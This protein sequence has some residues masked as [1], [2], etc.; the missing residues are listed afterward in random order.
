MPGDDQPTADRGPS[1]ADPAETA[2]TSDV[3]SAPAPDG[4]E[5]IGPYRLLS[6]IGEGGFGVVWEADQTE[7][8]RRRVAMKVIKPGM[9]SK[10]VVARFEAER[11]AL[12]VMDHPCIAKVLDGGTTPRD[13][14]SRPYFVMELVRGE[15]ITEFCDKHKLDL[16]AR[17]E[18]FVRVCEAVQHAHTKG[19]IHRDL[20]PSN[21]LVQYQDG[22]PAP[23]VIDFGVAK[24]LNQR[25][26][27]QTIFTDRGQMIGTPEYM[28]PEQAEMSGLD[29]DTRSDVYSL[30]VVLYE[31]LTGALPFDPT[32]LR[33]AGF[34]EI[35]RIIREVEPPKPSTR[36][37][38]KS[39]SPAPVD[40]GPV[41]KEAVTKTLRRDL[42]WV[43]MQCLD[44]SRER[45]YSSAASLGDD[46]VRFLQGDPV[47]AGP[48]GVT[49]RVAKFVH[50]NRVLVVVSGIALSF[51][52][53]AAGV[54]S[55]F[56]ISAAQAQEKSAYADSERRAA[57]DARDLARRAV[58]EAVA[59]M[60][61][62]SAE[63]NGAIGSMQTPANSRT[64][65]GEI[66]IDGLIGAA[67]R[68]HRTPLAHQ[69]SGRDLYDITVLAVEQALP[70]DLLAQA[71]IY[72]HVASR[73]TGDADLS[74]QFS[75]RAASLIKQ[76]VVSDPLLIASLYRNRMYE[77]LDELRS[78]L[79]WKLTLADEHVGPRSGASQY[80]LLSLARHHEREGRYSDAITVIREGLNRHQ[81]DDESSSRFRLDSERMLVRSLKDSGQL[82]AAV[83][84]LER[85]YAGRSSPWVRAR[86]LLERSELYRAGGKAQEAVTV[87][88]QAWEIISATDPPPE[89][90]TR[91]M[92]RLMRRQSN[93]IRRALTELERN[94]V[95][96]NEQEPNQGHN[97]SAQQWRDRLQ[98]FDKLLQTNQGS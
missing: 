85:Q 71:D 95:L 60:V 17:V 11:Q 46:L 62:A 91:D 25:L 98:A 6:I 42:D 74:E 89:R 5:R 90:Y 1:D 72:R 47:A 53:L 79:E 4:G 39:G 33:A 66:E 94:F 19:V 59:T 83:Q 52:T 37:G 8:V 26:T 92:H 14:G 44:K 29:I 13:Q 48:P 93:T 2:D 68:D 35:Q 18:L 36:L 65:P 80:I 38:P 87:A 21:I 12:A 28:S 27:E 30:G 70:G 84:E 61:E 32:T 10:A 40:R 15:P 82:D 16:D 34:A 45:R 75:A 51:A 97:Q 63:P 57:E 76:C 24:A 88:K 64:L 7:P 78:T 73:M 77:D 3:V 56:A 55:W 67:P 43:V 81:V 9:D 23:K 20:K 22:R 31:L 96:L 58:R 50:R 86:N 54:S 41:N 69:Q 49:W